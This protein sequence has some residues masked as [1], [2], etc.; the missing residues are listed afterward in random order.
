M[1]HASWIVRSTDLISVRISAL[2]SPAVQTQAQAR[3]VFLGLALGSIVSLPAFAS[4]PAA[5]QTIK[6]ADIHGVESLK[7]FEQMGHDL[8]VQRANLRYFQF[9]LED[10]ARVSLVYARLNPL[11]KNGLRLMPCLAGRTEPTSVG[12]ARVK[13]LAAVNG[14]YF[15]LSD[16][17]SASY[18]V[19]NGVIEADPTKNRALVE[20]EK[21]K[22]FLPQIFNRSELR[23]LRQ[24]SSGRMHYTIACHNEPV[25]EDYLLVDSLQGGPRLLPELTAEREAFVRTEADRKVVDSIGCNRTAARTFIGLNEKD[26]LFIV[27]VA[28]KKQDE[29]SA[30]ISLVTAAR[31]LSALGASEGLNFDGGTSATMIVAGKMVVGRIPETLVKSTLCLVD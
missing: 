18:I 17:E 14:G 13:A 23:V 10:G 11:E 12:A 1:P 3:A 21:L 26:E 2:I 27:C 6:L 24:K 7:K 20:N 30:G 19:L 22:P 15:N 5:D 29:F 28:G 16:G 25:R 4:A 31:L 9:A 8:S